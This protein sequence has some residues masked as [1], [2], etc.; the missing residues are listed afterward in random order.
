VNVNTDNRCYGTVTA[1]SEYT[2]YMT[3]YE[4]RSMRALAA[5]RM[6]WRRVWASAAW[7]AVAGGDVSKC[8]VSDMAH[9]SLFPFEVERG[10]CCVHVN[11]L[12]AYHAASL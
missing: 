12:S 6:A 4:T 5:L 1:R 10:V 11:E 3:P 8:S 9:A 2:P 7:M